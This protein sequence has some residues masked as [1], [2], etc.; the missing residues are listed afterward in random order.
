MISPLTEGQVRDYRRVATVPPNLTDAN[1]LIADKIYD[2]DWFR[3]ALTD[4]RIERCI[5]G[6]T[7]RKAPFLYDTDHYQQRE[8]IERMF[9]RLNGYLSSIDQSTDG[10]RAAHRNQIRSMRSHVHER[11]LHRSYRHLL[12]I[13]PVPSLPRKS[14]RSNAR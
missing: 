1:V 4:L 7:N 12:V 9:G 6:R 10:Q 14:R 11:H 2:S 5:P 8:R 3:E 13:S